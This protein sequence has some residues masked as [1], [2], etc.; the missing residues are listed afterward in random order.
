M[1]RERIQSTPPWRKKGPRR[2]CAFAVAD[3]HALGFRGMSTVRVQLFFSFTRDGVDYPC[4]QVGRSPDIETGMW[5][6][7]P[8][9]KEHTRLTTIVRLDALLRGTHHIP[10][11]G[12]SHIPVG[13][14][15]IQTCRR[16]HS[17]GLR[18][19]LCQS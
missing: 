10:V 3:Q 16:N 7:E 11:Y 13:F 15:Y 4:T 8:E 9:M 5:I 18:T 2:D 17:T 12:D 19:S 14:R 1:C 6:L